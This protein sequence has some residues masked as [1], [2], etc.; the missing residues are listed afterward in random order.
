MNT[1]YYHDSGISIILNHETKTRL[2]KILLKE[3]CNECSGRLFIY[4]S[5]ESSCICCVNNIYHNT[6]FEVKMDFPKYNLE[7][8]IERKSN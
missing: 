6:G 1:K 5:V 7:P 2:E 8:S 3:K 4:N